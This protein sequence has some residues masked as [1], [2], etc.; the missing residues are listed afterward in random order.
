MRASRR[1]TTVYRLLYLVIAIVLC[2]LAFVGTNTTARMQEVVSPPLPRMAAIVTET[3]TLTPTLTLATSTVVSALT[4]TP[5]VGPNDA[6][7]LT[8]TPEPATATQTQAVPPSQTPIATDTALPTPTPSPTN[9]TTP[10]ESATPTESATPSETPVLSSSETPTPIVTPT[11]TIELTATETVT[12][13]ATPVLTPTP[14]I[15][16]TATETV[17]VSATPVLTPTPAIELT[18]TAT[19]SAYIEISPTVTVT[20]TSIFTSTPSGSII[21]HNYAI[22]TPMAPAAAPTLVPSA[23]DPHGSYN[24][25]TSSC[26]ACHRTHTAAGAVLRASAPEESVCFACHTA[27]GPSNPFAGINIQPAFANNTNT[28]TSFFKHDVAATNGVH[29]VSESTFDQFSGANRHVEC[30]DCH[31][32]HQATRGSAYPPFLQR[33][34][35]GV[36]GVNPSWTSA[37]LPAGYTFMPQAEREY[38]VCFKCHSSFAILPA[39]SPDGWNG[40]AYVANGLPK[41]TSTDGNQ[42]LDS[43]DMAREFNPYNASFHPVTAQGVN[44]NIPAG[45]WTPGSGMSSASLIYCSSCHN[46]PDPSTQGLGPHGSSRLHILQGGAN[47]TT[48]DARQTPNSQEVCFQ[49]HNYA[50]YAGSG[51]GT[52]TNFRIGSDNLHS[53]HVAG[54]GASC[55]ACHDSHGSEQLF[56]INFDVTVVTPNPGRNSQTAY[57]PTTNGGSCALSCH[58]KIHEP[59]SYTR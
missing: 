58:G 10:V 34:M 22:A 57:V 26:A 41:M 42:V 45:S 17:T 54:Q 32:P 25:T 8:P 6:S 14:T 21:V 2:L 30:E 56:L 35:N 38:E 20:A 49:C 50:T 4:A 13:T 1:Y 47:Y 15:E 27:A 36:S 11:P 18:A 9:S 55:Y 19:I 28:A 46:N 59:L 53:K 31:E 7:T 23:S 40:T 12:V 39:Y 16:L 3:P 51:S 5:G 37:G 44:Q 52:D 33:V 48:V 29:Q 43:R 24:T